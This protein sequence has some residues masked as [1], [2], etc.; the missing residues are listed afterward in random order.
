MPAGPATNRDAAIGIAIMSA[1]MLVAPF[2]DLFAKLA[3]AELVPGQVAQG[4]FAAQTLILIPLVV[5]AGQV[6]RPHLAHI[7]A[8]FC[9]A[10]AILSI[11]TA[12]QVMPIANAIAIFFVE[13]LILTLLSALI[14]K[15]KLGWRRLSAVSLGLVGAMIVLRPNLAAYGWE[16]L[17]PL[18]T[19]VAFAFYM[20]ILRVMS[21]GGGTLATQFWIG[22]TATVVL[23]LVLVA[24]HTGGV[25][26]LTLAWPSNY[27]LLL[28]VSA[29][30]LGCLV[31]Q[32]IAQALARAEAG[33]VAPLQYLEIVAA[34]GIGWFIFG[35][36]PDRLTWVGTLIIIASGVYVF[37]RERNLARGL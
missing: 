34:T 37:R 7:L 27:A 17:L 10:I 35:D 12:L 19:A 23:T 13:P 25:E 22:T 20:L 36:W 24:G 16:A 9:A 14:L 28:M 11:N 5:F 4:R 33:A 15:E 30:A 18:I 1:A 6:A 8:G 32:M 3:T 21:P 2:M 31:H 26:D 29:G